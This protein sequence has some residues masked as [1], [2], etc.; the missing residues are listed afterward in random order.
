M[1]L[2]E[3]LVDG[4]VGHANGDRRGEAGPLRDGGLGE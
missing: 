4:V 1:A 3:E 2:G